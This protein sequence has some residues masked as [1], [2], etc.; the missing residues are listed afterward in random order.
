[1]RVL[2]FGLLIC[3]AISRA[4]PQESSVDA[5]G[6][7]KYLVGASHLP[8]MGNVTDHLVHGR[9]NTRWFAA[10]G[11]EVEGDLRARAYAG[12]TVEHTPDF[13][14]R[15]RNDHEFAHLDATLWSS[16]SSVG[17]AEIDRLWGAWT[18]NEWQVTLG[19]QRVAMGTC[20]VC[21][22]TDVFNPYS[23]L[24][25]DYEERPAF[26]GSR[27]QYYAGP[28]STVEVDIKPGKTS[29]TAAAV[30]AMSTNAWEY[31][32]HLMTGVRGG[33]AL[34]GGSWAGDI[35]GGGFRGEV[36]VSQRAER[37]AAGRSVPERVDGL[38]MVNSLSVDYTF[39]GSL[40][41]HGEALYSSE[42]VTHDA[43]AFAAEA[44]MLGLLSPARWSVFVESSYDVSPLVRASVFCI[45]NPCDGSRVLVPSLTWSVVTD[46]DC[47]FIAL[48]FGGGP[49]TE[50]G[51]F[52]TAGYARLSWSF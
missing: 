24:D 25:F 39:P 9:L 19:R 7:L 43:S 1:M 23:I 29:R 12:G 41:L 37:D 4:R 52:G 33:R 48:L 51:G 14:A 36:L 47:T 28:L 6:Y 11:L 42:G 27:I 2:F 50:F 26:D 32:F 18:R 20:L 17:Y 22:P 38:M 49:G 40:Y 30:A 3:A 35:A 44:N 8:G 16:R 13:S 21:N 5:G 34:V 10:E 45:H 31:D 46:L 15:I